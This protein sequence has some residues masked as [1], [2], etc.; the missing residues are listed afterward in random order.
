MEKILIVFGSL[1]TRIAHDEKGN[2][3]IIFGMLGLIVILV[4]GIAID[5]ARYYSV[6]SRVQSALDSAVL[7]GIVDSSGAPDAIAMSIFNSNIEKFDKNEISNP[8]FSKTQ[9][10]NYTGTVT[11]SV[12]NLFISTI[13][14]QSISAS[15]ESEAALNKLSSSGKALCLIALNATAPKAINDSASSAVNAP[16]CIVQ[17]NS[18]NSAAVSLSGSARINASENCYVGG[19]SASGSAGVSPSPDPVC[20]PLADPFVSTPTPAVGIC[21]KVN[22]KATANETLSPGVYCGGLTVSGVPVQF[23]SGLYIIKDGLLT[24]SGGASMSGTGVTF[25]LTGV[26]AGV[27]TSGGSSWHL[28]AMKNGSLAG[29]V[30]FLDP[31]STPASKSV[32]SGGSEM[33]FDG[34]LYFAKQALNLSGGSSAFTV[35]PFTSYIAD[36]FTLSGSST[37]NINND[38]AKSSTIIPP[39]LLQG[40][41]GYRPYLIR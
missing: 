35:S 25:F 22:Y 30:F 1:Y 13:G 26:N 40:S 32:L 3:T 15:I 38:T 19:I 31:K 34:V 24:A 11:V 41:T 12:Y 23:S 21:D 9:N 4:A 5:V 16:N 14:I 10:G 28:T 27:N 8:V 29:F 17:V 20:K 7:A 18:N 39:E 37:L 6:R 33:Y 2:L 36:T